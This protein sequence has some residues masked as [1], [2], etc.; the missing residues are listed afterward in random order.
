MARNNWARCIAEQFI[1]TLPSC[2]IPE[3]AGPGKMWRRW[4]T[5]FLAYFDSDGA[6]NG[7]AVAINGIIELCRRFARRFRNFEHHRLRILI[8][9]RGFDAPPHAQLCKADNLLVLFPCRK[10]ALAWLATA[11]PDRQVVLGTAPLPSAS[12]TPMTGIVGDTLPK[13]TVEARQLTPGAVQGTTAGVT[14]L[15]DVTGITIGMTAPHPD[16]SRT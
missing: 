16:L 1:T 3:I 15:S 10:S 5:A 14:Q 7:D 6:S 12:R 2:P 9:A 13:S 8:I 11:F 4:R